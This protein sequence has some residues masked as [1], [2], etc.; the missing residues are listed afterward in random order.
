M[1]SNSPAPV[2][3]EI[4][5]GELP[6][7]HNPCQRQTAEADRECDEFIEDGS[8]EL[9]PEKFRIMRK[10]HRIQIALDGG[11]VKRVVLKA[12]MVAHDQESKSGEQ[13]QQCQICGGEIAL[14]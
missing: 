8:L 11:E 14:A 12:R 5:G 2:K 3:Q 10:Q 7:K 1:S 4:D 13:G 9:K 6:E